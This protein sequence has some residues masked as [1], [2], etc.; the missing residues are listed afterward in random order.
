MRIALGRKGAITYRETA[1]K[2]INYKEQDFVA[3]ILDWTDGK[4]V[5]VVLD[6]VGGETFLSSLNAVRVGEIVL[7]N[8]DATVHQHDLPIALLGMSFLNRM[9]IQQNGETMTLK[10]RY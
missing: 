1:V 4:G 7:N 3:E 2:I 10:K 5:D 9:E 6:T 8:V